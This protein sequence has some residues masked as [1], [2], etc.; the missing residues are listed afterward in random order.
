MRG[1]SFCERPLHIFARYDTNKLGTLNSNCW[2]IL[3]NKI[4]FFLGISALIAV[5]AVSLIFISFGKQQYVS[6]LITVTDNNYH[7]IPFAY[8]GLEGNGYKISHSVNNGQAL[9]GQ[10]PKGNYAVKVWFGALD[11]VDHPLYSGSVLLERDK[12]EVFV[13]LHNVTQK[14]LILVSDPKSVIPV[15]LEG[16]SIKIQPLPG[17]E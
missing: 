17:Q 7:T 5:V 3:M 16:E 11:R 9:I 10:L 6:A 14:I 1:V 12:Q 8:A 2:R 15:S 4:K 13:Q